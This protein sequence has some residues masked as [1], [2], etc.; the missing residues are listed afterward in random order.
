LVASSAIAF[1]NVVNILG[2]RAG[3]GVQN[4]V[5]ACKVA[6][7]GALVIGLFAAGK[8][9]RII[10]AAPSGARVSALSVGAGLVAILWAYEGWHVVSFTAGE[11]RNPQRDLPR[12]LAWGVSLVV[13][14][15]VLANTAYMAVLGPAQLRATDRAAATAMSAAYGVSAAAFGNAADRGLDLRLDERY[16]THGTARLLCDGEGRLVFSGLWAV[17]S[18]DRAPVLAIVAQ[19]IWSC[20][21]TL[22]G[23]FQELFTYVIFTSWMFYGATVL[24]VLVLRFRRPELH[25]PYRVPGYPWIPVLF[26]LAAAFITATTIANQPR[27][28]FYGL[29]LI[30][31]GLPVY[32]LLFRPS[33]VDNE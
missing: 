17:E 8:L 18:E 20:V 9:E 1:V 31:L 26:V 32:W 23:A 14:V 27:N 28:A 3:K 10:S 30:L 7:I 4:V 33:I 13:V 21:L 24:G 19:G 12:S 5:T 2:L 15:Y 22:A 29:G 11:F 16:G 25:R 6:G